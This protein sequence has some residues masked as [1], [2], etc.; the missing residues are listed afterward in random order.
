MRGDRLQNAP[1]H[2]T[3][4]GNDG[5]PLTG[6]P[7][8]LVE[9][10]VTFG[11]DPIQSDYVLDHPSIAALHARLKRTDSNDF[12]I[13]DND[14]VAGTWVN[15][16]PVP[17]DGCILKHGDVVNFGQ[18]VFRFSLRK[19]PADAEPKIIPEATTE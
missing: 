13:I 7:L 15:Y 10:E 4:L 2:L 8:P 16:D 12:L 6:R 19:P 14:T 9:K 5:E 11:T 17:K 18:L 3:R 1:A